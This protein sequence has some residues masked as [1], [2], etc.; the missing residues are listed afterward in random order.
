VEVVLVARV[1]LVA[2]LGHSLAEVA[3][4]AGVVLLTSLGLGLVG[5]GPDPVLVELVSG[6]VEVFL[7]AG[8]GLGPVGLDPVLVD[9]VPGLG[10]SLVLSLV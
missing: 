2:S 1:V 3:L 9:V 8:L 5:I 7:V 6:L 10:V 4:G